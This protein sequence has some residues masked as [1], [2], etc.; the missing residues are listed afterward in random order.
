[1]SEVFTNWV[2]N[3]TC[4]PARIL[5]PTSEAEVQ[6]AVGEAREVRCVA[7]GHSFTPIHLTGDTLLTMEGLHGVLG[8]DAATGRIRAL[9]GTSVEELGGP[10]WEAGWS[11]AN[12]GDIDTQGIAGA[13]STSTHGSG[14]ALPSFSAAV[15]RARLVVASGDVLEIGEDDP[16]LPA[17]QVCVG[18]LGVLTELE[19]QAVPRHRLVERIEQWPYQ[20]AFGR[21][22]EL[23]RAHRHYSFFYLPTEHSAA[24]Y[25]LDVPAG[26]QVAETC[27]VK[28]Y[29]EAADDVPDSAEPGRRVGPAFR[30]YPDVFE[31]NFHEL[32]Y[33]VPFEC[34]QEAL[35]AMRRLMLRSLPLSVFPME[36]RTVAREEAWLSH[37]YGRDSLVISV[38]GKPG[39]DYGP[40]L[41]G[42][43]EVLGEYDARVHFG[44]LHFLTRDE[45]LA[46]YPRA[47]DFIELRRELDPEGKFLN[48]HLWSLFA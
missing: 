1:M 33:F 34:A 39:T 13:V 45:L 22:D 27:Y 26:M 6:A 21:L 14:L 43:H 25:D 30:I 9:P 16:R 12:Q 47:Q 24:L 10:L 17:V 48:D 28:I 8:V 20:E 31:A 46:R 37:S 2:G 29:D 19:V 44:K 23:A 38:S 40:Y 35:A 3:Q 15:T 5:T 18:M 7:T 36:V 42:V 11:L 32:E 4:T 41:R